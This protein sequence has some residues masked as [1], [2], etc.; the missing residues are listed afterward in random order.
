MKVYVMNVNT[1]SPLEVCEA[2]NELIKIY[3]N[4]NVITIIKDR[5][6]HWIYYQLGGKR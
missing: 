5:L 1:R 6:N 3:R 4:V 2:I